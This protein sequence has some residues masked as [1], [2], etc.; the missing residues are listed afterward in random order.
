[1]VLYSIIKPYNSGFCV[2]NSHTARQDFILDDIFSSGRNIL[3]Y[4]PNVFYV[5]CNDV[6]QTQTESD[7]E[8]LRTQA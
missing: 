8:V 5:R 6:T 7:T 4:L 3:I 1:M 2:I